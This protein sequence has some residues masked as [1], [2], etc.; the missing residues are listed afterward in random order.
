VIR[1]EPDG[2]GGLEAVAELDVGVQRRSIRVPLGRWEPSE[3]DGEGLRGIPVVTAIDARAAELI[4]AGVRRSGSATVVATTDQAVGTIGSWM[5][6]A[7]RAG[8]EVLL[9]TGASGSPLDH[10]AALRGR[11]VPA[12]PL[13]RPEALAALLVGVTVEVDLPVPAAEGPVRAA[14]RS[15]ISSALH[16][17]G[18]HHLVEVDARP[19]FEEAGRPFET[20]DLD[21]LGAAAAGVLAGRLA[22]ANRRWRDA[23]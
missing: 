21:A 20:A 14:I 1:F 2:S 10:I 4:V 16:L 18:R 9:V 17:D 3:A 19:A 13:A 12:L 23:D 22:A 8:A 6:G 15:R 5:L 7:A 11:A